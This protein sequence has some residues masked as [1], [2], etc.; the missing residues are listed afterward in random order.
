M[1]LRTK[2]QAW[3]QR[4]Q[5]TLIDLALLLLA[6]EV[7][8]WVAPAL[9]LDTNA[10]LAMF[11][12][13]LL[14]PV[15]RTVRR[16]TALAAWRAQ[17][18]WQLAV[19]AATAAAAVWGF[20][21]PWRALLF[22]PAWFATSLATHL[23]CANADGL[24]A[25]W[26]A[27]LARLRVAGPSRLRRWRQML[28]ESQLETLAAE[29]AITGS[30]CY[31]AACFW[32][33]FW[34]SAW[35]PVALTA[36][37]PILRAARG[38]HRRGPGRGGDLA[39][40]LAAT[41]GLALC[42]SVLVAWQQATVFTL[43]HVVLLLG[44]TITLLAHRLYLRTGRAGRGGAGENLRLALLLVA[45]LWLMRGFAQPG[46]HGTGDARWYGTMLA[47]MVAQTRA[48]VFP[49]W[50]GQSIYQ[51]N[52]AIY[53][54]RVA[55]AFHYLGALLDTLTLHTLGVLAL[56]NLLITLIGVAAI[57]V[58][59]CCV[60]A[61][62]PARRWFA[63]GLALLF[64]SCP[65]VLGLAYN[66]DLFMS[67]TTLPWVLLTCHASVRSFR[68]RGTAGSLLLLG[69]A[70]GLCWWGHS[71]I[72]LW[73]SLMAG[74]GQVV[75]LV[76]QRPHGRE[77]AVL[78]GAGAV[79]LAVA[80][81]PLGSVLLF[82]PEPGVNAAG[83]QAATPGTILYFLR[84]VFPGVLRPLSQYGRLL[85]DFQLG[86]ALWA[87]LLYGLWRL[88]RSGALEAR[89]LLAFAL[90]FGILLT[91]VPGL[92]P[93]L[94]DAVPAVVRNV[95]GNWAMN[96]L[97]LL[98]AATIVFGLAAAV[99]AG[100]PR[101]RA[102]G[103]ILAAALTL[104]CGWSLWQAARFPAGS[105]RLRVATAAAVDPLRPENVVLTSY[106]Y[107]VFPRP[108][109]NFSHGVVDPALDHRLLQRGSFAPI[110][111][112]AAAALAGGREIDREH[113][114]ARIEGATSWLELRT[115]LVLQPGR[116][117]L[118]D[119]RF[120]DPAAASGVLELTGRN[121]F[122]E[123]ALP[124]YGEQ[125]S[126]GAGGRHAT[127]LPLWTTTAQPEPVRVQFFPT[128]GKGDAKDLAP[129]ADVRLI[130]YDPADLPVQ[131][132]H[133]IRYS[134]RV[135]SPVAAWLET[136]RMYQTGYVAQVNGESALVRKSPWGLVCVA[137]P[138]GESRVELT[139]KP[140][141]GLAALFWLSVFTVAALAG[142]SVALAC[143]RVA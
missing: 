76:R 90:L 120:Q 58:A 119:W 139:Y 105:D 55:P 4:H 21:V 47:D 126:F 54:L 9:S 106:A 104:G 61:L 2:A 98:L 116:R 137:V 18:P 67:W 115:R 84:Q 134:A 32:P 86:Y 103:M 113:F 92:T 109:D 69:G 87:A 100:A 46:L 62:L 132:D 85:S 1:S 20:A 66:T 141:G 27:N 34:P 48:G 6:A 5:W 16:T 74:T 64:L 36:V 75:R 68:E 37:W 143:R 80:A 43:A 78:A 111:T 53:P 128:P 45:A 60:A 23:A 22:L 10:R 83:F 72:A 15:R 38:W 35:T 108:P 88:R 3:L 136:P 70:L 95:T 56:Q 121:F 130:E 89:L 96:R 107:L 25:G 124:D 11:A 135:R 117:Y 51:F 41:G 28:A 65:G 24:K 82:P 31:L 30:W 93:F 138:A 33:D 129:F 102:S 63:T 44:S 17:L 14:M 131:V 79:F 42:G 57:F 110:A 52:G 125:A 26:T 59:Y 101:R 12:L 50:L 94:W 133:W 127:W 97:Y 49:V 99:A 142:R 71:P 73:L 7:A 77:W 123:Y 19:M 39:R 114:A 8:G 140:P 91:P 29:T 112:N 81:Y 118:L 40:L 13:A 122:R